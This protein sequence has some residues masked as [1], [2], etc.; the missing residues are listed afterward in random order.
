MVSLPV[1]PERC[2]S[3]EVCVRNPFIHSRFLTATAA[4]AIGAGLAI[5]PAATFATSAAAKAVPPA[6]APVKAKVFTLPLTKVGEINLSQAAKAEHR[7]KVATHPQGAPIARSAI[8]RSHYRAVDNV[9]ISRRPKGR[10]TGLP[11]AANSPLTTQNVARR[12]R[13]QRA[14]ERLASRDQ[15]WRRPRAT[16]PGPVRGQR[17]RHGVHQQRPRHLRQE[18]GPDRGPDRVGGR[19][20]PADHGLL[21]RPPLLLRRADQALVLS[22]VHGRWHH[23]L[24]QG[25]PERPVRGGKQRGRP[26]RQLH[27]LVV[28]HHRPRAAPL[29]VLR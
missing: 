23:L 3:R 4:V 18:R 15:R 20:P 5:A 26:H 12:A 28:G 7:T 1:R 21:L 17:L 19:V 9:L 24:G 8:A 29:P 10:P 11:R 27:H 25:H 2:C 22:G 6:S 13:V 14:D 16:G